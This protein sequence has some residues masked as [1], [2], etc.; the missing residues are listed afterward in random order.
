MLCNSKE[1]NNFRH[2]ETEDEVFVNGIPVA[3]KVP[4]PRRKEKVNII[5]ILL[6]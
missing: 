5:Q 3:L 4:E 2:K 1:E 6:S